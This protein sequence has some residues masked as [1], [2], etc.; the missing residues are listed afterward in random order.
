M[1]PLIQELASLSPDTAV[2][3]H[4]FDMTAA[5]KKEQVVD[6]AV[7][8]CPL[9]FPQTALVCAFENKKALIVLG[10][11]GEATAVCAWLLEKTSYKS[12]IPFIY[13]ST[14]DGVKV[15]HDDGTEFDYRT[16]TA[17]GVLAFVSSF[18]N[19]LKFSAVTGHQ[20]IKRSNWAKKI[21]QGKPIAYDWT[22]IVIEPPKQKNEPL[23]GAHAS[24][25]WH[26]RRGHWRNVKKT[27]KHIWVRDCE[28]GNK[29]LGAVFHDYKVQ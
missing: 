7:L 26:E 11:T 14:P 4:W 16:S 9:P 12:T 22:T 25:R 6:H 1:S 8:D 21:R 19:S 24:P 27:G 13:V 5:Y 17:V 10:R 29:A 23:G 18:L 20:P 2:E 15:R 3:Y 28:V